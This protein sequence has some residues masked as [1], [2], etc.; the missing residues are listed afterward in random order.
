MLNKFVLLTATA[1]ALCAGVAFGRSQNE[2]RARQEEPIAFYAQQPDRLQA[3]EDS[4]NP[5]VR[6]GL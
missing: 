1:T 5:V 6:Y 4:R 2:V 3:I